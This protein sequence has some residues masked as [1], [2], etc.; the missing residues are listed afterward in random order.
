MSAR[1]TEEVTSGMEAAAGS[2]AAPAVDRHAASTGT[3]PRRR[4]RTPVWFVLPALA[5]CRIGPA[6]SRQPPSDS[7]QRREPSAKSSS[8]WT[9]SWGASP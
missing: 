8:S 4:T 9:I 7:T 6:C 2:H 5:Q 3:R 1:H